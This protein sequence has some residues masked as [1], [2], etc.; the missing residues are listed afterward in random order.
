MSTETILYIIL[1]GIIALLLALFQYW[2][3]AKQKGKQ[4]MLFTFLRFVSIF[5]LLLLLINPKFEQVSYYNEKPNLVIALDNSESVAYLK[6]EERAKTL[7]NKVITNPQIK[8]RFEIDT[9][10]FGNTLKAS[11]SVTFSDK[12]TNLASVFGEL[13]QIY[14]NT[15]TPTLII[16]DG[17]QTYGND[18]EFVSDT[19]NQPI[20]PVILGDTITYADLRI[21]QLNVNR[22]AY[23]KNR[24]PVEVILTYNG[25]ENVNSRFVVTS[26]SSTIYSKAV[27]FTKERNSQILNFDLP[28]NRVGVLSYN[29]QILPL[30]IEKNT[31]NNSKAFAVE[32]IDQKT[33]VAIISDIVH[34]DLGALKKSIESNEQRSA[35]FLK[36]TINVNALN[37]YQLVILYQ[38]N[39]KFKPIYDAIASQGK[40]HFTITGT[41]TDW[42]FLSNNFEYFDKDQTNQTEDYQAVL[43][44]GYN[45][46]II[47]DL[48]FNSFPPLKSSFGD[49]EFTAPVETILF[50]KF[51]NVTTEQPLLSTLENGDRRQA[52]LFGENIWKWRAQSYLNNRSFNAFD[53]FTGKLVQY[54]ASNKRRNRL[55]VS[56]DSFYDGSNPVKV[57]AQYFDKNY[58]FDNRGSLNIIVRDKVSNKT[59]TLPFIL[60][61]T[62]YEVDLSSL[63][64]SDYAFTESVTNEGLKQSGSFT[65]LDFNVEQQFLNADVTKLQRLATNS[66][67]TAYFIANTDSLV[68]QLMSD[69]R[70][71]TIQKS[72]KKVVPLIDWK[73][74]LALIAL[75]LAIEWF[76]RKY[77]GLI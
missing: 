43:N 19:Y 2:F 23:L 59:Q 31:V 69:K 41:Q 29:A 65:I 67:G 12:Q 51:G 38:P 52:F 34:P 56:Y 11:D 15:I 37:D 76:L 49:I 74:L 42:N 66:N 62:S 10:L 58:Q 26:G 46:F 73:Y 25:N 5:S 61:N 57:S 33:N 21:Q 77:N 60:N 7:F 24:F 6:Q 50:K 3:S 17:N 8:E 9:Y 70:F 45:T 18:Y 47:D 55:D 53:N 20:F 36:P 68:A 13:S 14:K 16:S 71:T 4:W 48:K 32:V 35:T 72:T 28:A 22:Y 75:S 63:P 39:R 54:L 27:S 40:N 44:T 1:S 30:T 64:A